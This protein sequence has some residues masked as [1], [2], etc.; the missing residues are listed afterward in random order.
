MKVNTLISTVSVRFEMVSKYR[1][2]PKEVILF[3][4]KKYRKRTETVSVSVCFG[5][6]RKK[7]NPFRRTPYASATPSAASSLPSCFAQ[8]AVPHVS[9]HM[10]DPPVPSCALLHSCATVTYKSI[11]ALV[12]PSIDL[13]CHPE[14]A[15][16]TPPPIGYIDFDFFF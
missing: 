13:G 15:P 10:P 5:S 9:R 8:V 7:K 6:N 14:R 12:W 11:A 16:Q 2:K 3:F 1:N 4:R